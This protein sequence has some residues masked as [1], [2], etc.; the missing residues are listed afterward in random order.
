MKD[1]A[2]AAAYTLERQ[3]ALPREIVEFLALYIQEYA[4]IVAVTC[5]PISE[6]FSQLD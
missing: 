4:Y 3:P 1:E 2:Y 6:L 5:I